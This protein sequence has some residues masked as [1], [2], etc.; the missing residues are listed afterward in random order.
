MKV[1]LDNAIVPEYF[2]C[3][4]TFGMRKAVEFSRTSSTSGRFFQAAAS[5]QVWLM[6][7]SSSEKVQLLLECG[8]YTRLYGILSLG[9][10]KYKTKN[11]L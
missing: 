10:A 9:V 5:L 7:N 2:K 11:C 1:K 4:Q 3:K 8:F 6:C